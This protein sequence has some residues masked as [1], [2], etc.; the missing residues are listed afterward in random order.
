MVMEP[1]NIKFEINLYHLLC[2]SV[3]LIYLVRV[4]SSFSPLGLCDPRT[5]A[6]QASLSM[7]FSRQDY[8][9]GLPFPSPEDIPDPGTEPWSFALQADSLPF[10]LQGS[11]NGHH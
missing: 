8:W 6:C 1:N 3:K 11:L 9:S 4:L 2:C 7:G 10:E 5:I